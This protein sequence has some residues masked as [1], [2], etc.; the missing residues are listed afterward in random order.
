MLGSLVLGTVLSTFREP[1]SSPALLLF[2]A[3]GFLGA[4]TTF[5]T[6]SF[7]ALELLRG[8]LLG[9]ALIYI[10]SSMIGGLVAVLLGTWLAN[11]LR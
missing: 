11:S 5:S 9:I 6:F 8:G 4:F 2:L 7:E 1:N 10:A 3:V